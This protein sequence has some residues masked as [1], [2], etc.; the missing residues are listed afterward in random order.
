[1]FS[2]KLSGAGNGHTRIGN[3]EGI[4]PSPLLSNVVDPLKTAGVKNAPGSNGASLK[5]ADVQNASSS[6]GA[7]LQSADV[8]SASSSNGAS[9]QTADIQS[10]PV[11]SK[12]ALLQTEKTLFKPDHIIIIRQAFAEYNNTKKLDCLSGIVILFNQELLEPIIAYI[13]KMKAN[14]KNDILESKESSL[15]G[16]FHVIK[17]Q[18]NLLENKNRLTG[19]H[20]SKVIKILKK[21]LDAVEKKIIFCLQQSYPAYIKA[22][23]NRSIEKAEQQIRAAEAEQISKCCSIVCLCGYALP[24]CFVCTPLGCC[25]VVESDANILCDRQTRQETHFVGFGSFFAAPCYG[26]VKLWSDIQGLEKRIEHEHGPVA[27]LM[28]L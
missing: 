17:M 15:P 7:S 14:V 10:A 3:I 22:K 13:T 28:K 6:N 19:P 18:K 8:Q 4:D 27:Q 26:S 24:A 23:Y 25:N 2:S 1:M 11:D 12:V 5:I 16:M 9:L 21:G 20:K